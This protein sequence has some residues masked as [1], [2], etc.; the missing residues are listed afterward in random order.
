MKKYTVAGAI[1]RRKDNQ[2]AM[3]RQS[4]PELADGSF[5]TL[6][7]GKLEAGETFIDAAIR[8][9]KEETGLDPQ[10]AELI[11]VC[12]YKNGKEG[13]MCRVEMYEFNSFKG[14]IAPN[15]PDQ[16]IEEADFFPISDAIKKLDALKWPMVK[17][18]AIAYLND[19]T[20]KPLHWVYEADQNEEYKLVSMSAL[21]TNIKKSS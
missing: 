12:E 2:V 15:D 11:Y 8:E 1:I 16:V 10:G 9:V 20:K 18:P 13:F 21:S 6:P 5:W 19:A 17:E 4:S 14:T 3:V 7:S